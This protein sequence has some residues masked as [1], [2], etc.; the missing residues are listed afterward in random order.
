M[1]YR[2]KN[3]LPMGLPLIRPTQVLGLE[4]NEYA[5]ELAQVAI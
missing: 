1:T 5:Q 3:G 4:I 2:A